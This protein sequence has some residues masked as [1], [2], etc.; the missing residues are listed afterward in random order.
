MLNGSN[1]T[2]MVAGSMPGDV[3][4]MRILRPGCGRATALGFLGLALAVALWA[5]SYKLSRLDFSHASKLGHVPVAKLWIE[6]RS[7]TVGIAGTAR[8]VPSN[9]RI[10]AQPGPDVLLAES[11]DRGF[12]CDLAAA[13]RAAQPRAIPFFHSAIPLRSPPVSL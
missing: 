9:S 12:D 3:N 7:G 8:L 5:F 13:V 1:A 10:F 11:P 6:Q 2:P 4:R